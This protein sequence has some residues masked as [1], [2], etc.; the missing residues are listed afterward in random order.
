MSEI[1]TNVLLESGTNEL[2]IM[3]FLID[4]KSYGINVA[5]ILEI[6]QYTE[7]LP[8]P[9]SSKFIEGVFNPRDEIITVVDLAKYLNSP[10]PAEGNKD[11]LIITKFNNISTAFHVQGVVGI[12]RVSWEC[13]EKPSNTIYPSG[14]GAATGIAKFDGKLITILDFEKIIVDINPE[15]AMK[16]P[17]AEDYEGRGINNKPI[18][19]VEDSPVLLKMI[20]NCL[21]VT[22]YN[23]EITCTNGQEALDKINEF[24]ES[25]GEI[26]DHIKCVITDIEM[27]KMDGHRLS[28]IIKTDPDLK[29]L[30]II[31]FSSLITEEMKRKGN[32]LGVDAQISKP[33][34]DKLVSLIDELILD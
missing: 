9:N 33:E 31:I 6:M 5:K 21:K 15:E 10:P 17:K 22:G 32:E 24:L 30:P 11:I 13:I 28:K 14:E 12:H 29:K 34:I 16:T 26:T 20:V 23:N 4:N 19:I 7:I 18:L 25:G 3:E 1:L 8:M 27:P 2:E